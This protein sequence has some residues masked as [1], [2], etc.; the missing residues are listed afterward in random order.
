MG[1]IC[2]LGWSICPEAPIASAP[3]SAVSCPSVS[4]LPKKHISLGIS[5]G[6]T[7]A[8]LS[9][10]FCSGC[11]LGGGIGYSGFEI[12]QPS[13]VQVYFGRSIC[14]SAVLASCF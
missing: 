7:S 12:L 10:K 3:I 13:S 6:F 5:V 14:R 1:H 11:M 2:W 8:I 9:H 4:R